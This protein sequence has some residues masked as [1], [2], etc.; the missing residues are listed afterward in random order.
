MTLTVGSVLLGLTRGCRL[1]RQHLCLSFLTFLVLQVAAA[2]AEVVTRASLDAIWDE[3]MLAGSSVRF[4]WEASGPQMRTPANLGFPVTPNT[5]VEAASL[6]RRGIEIQWLR[7][8]FWRNGGWVVRGG[9]LD[10]VQMGDAILEL[11]GKST[12]RRAPYFPVRLDPWLPETTEYEFFLLQRL[13]SP[14]ALTLRTWRFGS[15]DVDAVPVSSG[16]KRPRGVMGR[17]TSDAPA[18]SI[19]V[20]I[21]GLKQPF[22]ESTALSERSS[23]NQAPKERYSPSLKPVPEPCQ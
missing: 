22:S 1:R 14:C 17:M 2:S 7:E 4:F 10:S 11:Y 20:I 23:S 18:R 15:E 6:N 19:A 16:Q 12:T 21:T 5:L 3:H 9:L 8:G 13:G